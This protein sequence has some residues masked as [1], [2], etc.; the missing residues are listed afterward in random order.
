[1]SSNPSRDAVPTP[2]GPPLLQREH[3]RRRLND[4]EQQGRRDRASITDLQAQS[5]V[6]REIIAALAEQGLLDRAE[7]VN[8]EQALISARRIGAAVGPALAGLS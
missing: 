2:G 7:I 3:D 4:L 6:D 1:M 8:L 5:V